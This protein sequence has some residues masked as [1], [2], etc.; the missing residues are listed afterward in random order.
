MKTTSAFFLILILFSGIFSSCKKDKGNKNTI[1]GRAYTSCNM[2]P[3][4]NRKLYLFSWDGNY[5]LSVVVLDSCTTDSQGN[6]E[7]T[8]SVTTQCFCSSMKIGYRI[9]GPIIWSIPFSISYSMLPI[10]TKIENLEL[11]DTIRDTINVSLSVSNTLTNTDT[12]FLII[13][14]FPYMVAF[15]GPFSNGI[16][17]TLYN[18][19]FGESYPNTMGSVEYRIHHSDTKE[20]YGP[21][22]I[23][24]TSVIEIPID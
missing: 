7:L 2:N 24:G 13:P 15:P 19:G 21:L 1:S 23:C 4:S 3:M 12:L 18:E 8:P 9:T 17:Y 22:T 11:I 5:Y 20:L 6:F 16:I 10:N 14:D